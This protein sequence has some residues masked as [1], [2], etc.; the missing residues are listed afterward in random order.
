MSAPACF[1][2]SSLARGAKTPEISPARFAVFGGGNV[3]LFR[4]R[5]TPPSTL[6]FAISMLLAMV[7]VASMFFAA[8]VVGHYF[9]HHALWIM[10]GA[11]ALLAAGVLLDNF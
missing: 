6:V 1:I 5:L 11:Y 10:T 8:P 9:R 2:A 7:T 4:H 3:K